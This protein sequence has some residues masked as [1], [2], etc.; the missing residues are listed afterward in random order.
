M[1]LFNTHAHTL[2]KPIISLA[3]ALSFFLSYTQAF[4][5]KQ[6]QAYSHTLSF[7]HSLWHTLQ[8]TL[9]VRVRVRERLGRSCGNLEFISISRLQLFSLI[10]YK[11]LFGIR[12]FPIKCL[13]LTNTAV[14]V[15]LFGW[16]DLKKRLFPHLFF[17]KQQ[18]LILKTFFSLLRK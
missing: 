14:L 5:H 8:Q 9:T 4:T 15:C 10:T 7:T 11:L 16:T 6:Y 3:V 1:K 12:P 17:S 13:P 18:G 2:T